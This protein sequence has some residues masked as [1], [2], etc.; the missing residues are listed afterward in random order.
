MVSRTIGHYT[1]K[2]SQNSITVS[3]LIQK[4]HSRE[5]VSLQKG[6]YRFEN[7]NTT[8][9]IHC[10]VCQISGFAADS[11]FTSIGVE[12]GYEVYRYQ[13]QTAEFQGWLEHRSIHPDSPCRNPAGSPIVSTALR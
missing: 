7:D 13:Q 12:G 9:K 8:F 2:G 11:E 6:N 10:P 5:I 3:E 1:H 4:L